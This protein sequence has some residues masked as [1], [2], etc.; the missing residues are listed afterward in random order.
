MIEGLRYVFGVSG[1]LYKRNL[2]FYDRQTDSLW[3]QL[4]S[5]ALT[6]PLAGTRL[7]LIPAENTSWGEWR[8]VYPQT[9]VLSFVTGFARNYR[10]DPYSEV[11]LPGNPALWASV[12]GKERIYPFSELKK[13][14]GRV[15]DRL[16]GREVT[17][18]FYSRARTVRV[19]TSDASPVDSFVAFFD[20]LKA[21]Y[22]R[23]EIYRAPRR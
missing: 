19:E 22:P 5:Q 12:A 17:I 1:L 14:R 15:V 10:E 6:G 8:K 9:Q 4:L 2:L 11:P 18:V 23:A 21:F 7:A 3:S 13:A 16:G 20:D